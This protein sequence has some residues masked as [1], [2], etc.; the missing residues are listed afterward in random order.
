VP[1]LAFITNFIIVPVGTSFVLIS[2]LTLFLSNFYL[3]FLGAPLVNIIYIVLIKILMISSNIP[4][5]T[6]EL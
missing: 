6:L 1:F 5:L 3:G 2:F 4:Y